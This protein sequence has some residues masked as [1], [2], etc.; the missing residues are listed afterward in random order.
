MKPFIGMALRK[1]KKYVVSAEL[2]LQ[3][4]LVKAETLCASF[5]V[6]KRGV[7]EQYKLCK[8]YKLWRD[9]V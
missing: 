2:S 8:Q 3:L 1:N 5:S 6:R 7:G 4:S 9:H